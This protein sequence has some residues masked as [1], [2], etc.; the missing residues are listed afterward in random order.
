MTNDTSQMTN[1]GL[2]TW[3]YAV[4]LSSVIGH[5]SFRPSLRRGR[6]ACQNS[7][8]ANEKRF[9]GLD[10]SSSTDKLRAYVP[11]VEVAFTEHHRHFGIRT[12]GCA[13]QW[14]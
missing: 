2:H 9:V 3:D 7:K 5:L 13:S 12:L 8:A 11:S 14:G 6:D 1:I 10:S 4:H